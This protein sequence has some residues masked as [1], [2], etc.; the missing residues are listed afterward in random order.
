[1]SIVP[2]AKKL[3]MPIV[4]YR[5]EGGY[6]AQPRWSDVI[7]KGRM[8]AYVHEVLMPEEYDLMTDEALFSR[9]RDGLYVNEANTDICFYHKKS[10]EYLERA[11]YVCPTC[12]LSTFES[13][14]DLVTCLTCGQSVRY[15]PTKELRGE[16]FSFPFRFVAEWY[17]HQSA[18]INRLDVTAMCDTPIYRDSARLTEVI[19]YQNRRRLA[20]AAAISLFGNRIEISSVYGNQY[21]SF[22]ETTAVTVLGRN[23]LNIYHDGRIF[24]LK[25]SK[26]FNALK[27]VHIFHRYQNIKKGAEHEQFLGL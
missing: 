17:D 7:R 5:S 11:M 21:F 10:A 12:G 25:G 15:L 27:Y 18:F 19:P 1:P 9:I 14:N 2:L 24:Q 6:G 20:K 26:R 16:G 22:D 3:H 23:K 8:K 13:H 4:L